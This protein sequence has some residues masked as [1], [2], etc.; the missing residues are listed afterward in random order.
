M[1]DAG[2]DKRET[3]NKSRDRNLASV[4]TVPGWRRIVAPCLLGIMV[5][6]YVSWFSAKT[7]DIHR[8]LGTSSYDIGLYDQG[9]WLMSR[10][11]APFVTL[12][13]RNLLG[14]HA[15]LI[16]VF[17]VPLYWIVPGCATLLTVQSACIG[18]GAIPLFLYARRRLQSDLLG[19]VMAGA[20]LLH[21]AVGLTN[22]ENFH[23]DSAL[24]LLIPLALYAALE[25]KWRLYAIAVALALLV[26]EDVVLVLLPLGIWVAWRRDRRRGLLTIAATVTATLVGMFLLMRSLIGV[27]TRNTWRIPFNGP[28][29]FVRKSFTDPTEVWRYLSSEGRLFYLWQM[30]VPF[31]GIFLL[32]PEVALISLLVLTG[33]IVSNFW[34]QFHIGYHYSLVAVPALAFG[35]VYALGRLDRRARHLLTA[36]VAVTSVASATMWGHFDFSRKQ[37]YY[38]PGSHPVAADARELMSVI[39][40]NA[41]ISVFHSIAPHLAHRQYVY[42]FPNPFRVVLYGTDIAQE[43]SILPEAS[44]IEYVMLP[45]FLDAQMAA[46]WRAIQRSFSIVAENDSF[47][48]YRR[49]G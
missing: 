23:P 3:H 14:D 1:N 32:Q 30:T 36:V 40:D 4:R 21:P 29:G 27:P 16:L 11:K 44:S 8:G 10:F 22:F 39:P 43:G 24:G 49:S 15:S 45:K 12:M 38:W 13:G 35:T 2:E 48:V 7:I 42:Q 9:V 18:A 6:S 34:Y 41:R 37:L 28:L 47:V 26:K 31:G 5:A 17:L 19:L 33:N 46:D 20:W 25:R